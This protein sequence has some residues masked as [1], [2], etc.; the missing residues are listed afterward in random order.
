[1]PQDPWND[2]ASFGSS[3]EPDWEQLDA[4]GNV[5]AD[6]N[7]PNGFPDGDDLCDNCLEYDCE[8]ECEDEDE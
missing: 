5:V 3:R 6:S 1:M 7:Y 4:D 2:N 8:G